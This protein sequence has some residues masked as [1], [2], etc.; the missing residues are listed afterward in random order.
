[1]N[2]RITQSSGGRFVSNWHFCFFSLFFRFW[3]NRNVVFDAWGHY[4]SLGNLGDFERCWKFLMQNV[5]FFNNFLQDW[6]IWAQIFKY[7]TSKFQKTFS[8]RC[9]RPGLLIIF[10]ISEAKFG[11]FE[12]SDR[13]QS[14]FWTD[15]VVMF[16]YH[17]HSRSDLY[18]NCVY[19][20]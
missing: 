8:A 18:M 16:S 17:V 14:N 2:Y 1:M 19:L 12:R 11:S 13:F 4:G 6:L 15:L 10:S 9:W 5:G 3:Q 7:V 20:L